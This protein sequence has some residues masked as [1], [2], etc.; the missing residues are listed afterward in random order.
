[1]RFV[2]IAIALQ[3]LV[4]TSAAQS[5]VRILP[6]RAPAGTTV[7][8]R[9]QPSSAFKPAPAETLV[10]EI[11]AA[12]PSPIVIDVPLRREGRGFVGSF[13]VPDD[14]QALFVRIAVG[15]RVDDREHNAWYFPIHSPSGTPVQGA[16]RQR[17]IALRQGGIHGFPQRRDLV[18]A[19]SA[20]NA[21]RVAYPGSM[22]AWSEHW[23]I[24][25]E[26]RGESATATIR[27]E[28]DSVFSLLSDRQEELVALLPW[29]GRTGQSERREQAERQWSDRDPRGPVAQDVAW[30]QATAASGPGRRLEAT[31]RVVREFSIVPDDATTH[32]LVRE[33]VAAGAWDRAD[34]LIHGMP[35]KEPLLLTSLATRLIETGTTIDRASVLAKEAVNAAR[36]YDP[37]LKPRLVSLREYRRQRA[38][39]LPMALGTYGD[40]LRAL[41]YPALAEKVVAE[42]VHLTQGRDADLNHRYVTLLVELGHH[43]KAL[44]A[45][46]NALRAGRSDRRLLTLSRQS[47][48]VVHGSIQGFEEELA[49]LRVA[50]PPPGT[51]EKN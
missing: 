47:Y 51:R 40:A 42:A 41:G 19:R 38:F 39:E 15:E 27:T 31:E 4:S 12:G 49:R 46:G 34:E 1:M 44:E 8:V 36:N 16:H 21:E 45:A 13:R 11:L 6:E 32:V 33:A 2:P 35:R 7:S 43:E 50:L 5:K 30:R 48:S 23:E 26:E 9:Y 28:L 24:L 29:F 14:A 25:E 22:A 3:L 10:A 17:A 37:D 20:I 18:E